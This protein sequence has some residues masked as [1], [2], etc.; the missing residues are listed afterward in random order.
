[1]IHPSVCIS[2][3]RELLNLQK[4][5]GY[6]YFNSDFPNILLRSDIYSNPNKIKR[7][8]SGI[9]HCDS[10]CIIHNIDGDLE[11]ENPIIPAN[12]FFPSLTFEK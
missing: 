7:F 9:I 1:M 5:P 8:Y 12:P 3:K 2:N 6:V 4:T 11:M 10:N